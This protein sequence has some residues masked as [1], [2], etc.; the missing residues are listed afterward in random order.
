M[1]SLRIFHKHLESTNKS[2]DPTQIHYEN[3]RV[4]NLKQKTEVH[5]PNA[6]LS[7][8]QNLTNHREKITRECIN[9]FIAN[10]PHRKLEVT[11][12]KL[13]PSR[14]RLS[15]KQNDRDVDHM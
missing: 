8:Y 1:S 4:P 12:S 11:E 5:K 14:R 13:E 10:P 9:N 3:P 2:L 15:I 6:A 7:S